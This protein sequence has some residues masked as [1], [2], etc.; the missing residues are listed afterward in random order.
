MLHERG[1]NFEPAVGAGKSIASLSITQTGKD[2]STTFKP[3]AGSV[4]ESYK[5]EVTSDGQAAIWAVSSTGVV[6]GL[7]TF[8][9]LFYKHSSGRAWYTNMAPVSV[10]DAPKF[11]HRGLLLDVGRHFYPVEDIKRTI[12]ALSMAKMN[13]FHWHITEA[14]SWPLEV[15]SMPELAE[16]GRYAPGLT[17]S[18]E[19][20]RSVQEFGVLHGVQVI[21][22]IDMP[23]HVGIANSHP[24]LVVA[25][26]TQPYYKYCAEPPCGAFRLGD[27][28]VEAF[29][30]KLFDDLLPRLAPY[31]SYFHTGGDEYKA[32]NS[33]LDPNLRT[34]DMTKLKPLLQQFLDHA[35]RNVRKHG[36]VPFIWEE[37]V[38]EWGA[39][40]GN[41]T[42]IQSWYGAD[43]VQ[44]YAAA[45]HK[46]IDSSSDVYVSSLLSWF[47]LTSSTST[48]AAAHGST[49]LAARDR[50]GTTGAGRRKAGSSS[51]TTIH[52]LTSRQARPRT[53]SAAKWPCGARRL[54]RWAWT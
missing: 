3:L 24:E 9:Q 11:P 5:L 14:Q 43:S 40:V 48:A 8:T 37:M 26:D 51:T 33:L 22:E 7:E 23:G 27:A 31:T 52:C 34:D 47:Q 53:S 29:L 15:P 4:D 36:L 18:P 41:D 25:Y 50:R 39:T 19:D 45:G 49:T 1:S 28:K 6:R 54:T 32:A 35:H 13:V 21:V 2:N 42:V 17:Y 10:S 12:S 46:V 44:K 30:D 20:V 16:K 38:G